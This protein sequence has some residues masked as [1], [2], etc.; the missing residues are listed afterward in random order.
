MLSNLHR[1]IAAVFTRK[2]KGRHYESMK[3]DN[4]PTHKDVS[5]R[6]NDLNF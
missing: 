5:I 2:H 1:G 6:L 3:W 4:A